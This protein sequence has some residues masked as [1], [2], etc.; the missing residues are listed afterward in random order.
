MNKKASLLLAISFM[1]FSNPLPSGAFSLGIITD[2]HAGGAKEVVKSEKN[3]LY[4]SNYCN[5][6]KGVKE[7]GVD[8]ILTLGD[9]TLNGKPSEA[10]RVIE[11]MNG[12]NILWAKGNHDKEVA[13]K[14]FNTPNYYSK[15]IDNWKII[16]LDSSK[17][18][19]ADSGGFLDE[20]LT[21]LENELNESNNEKIFIAMHHKVFNPDDFIINKFVVL[22]NPSYANV[23]FHKFFQ[24]VIIKQYCPVFFPIYEKFINMIESNGKVKYVYSGHVHKD[25]GCFQ[26]NGVNYCAVPSLSTGDYEGYFEKLFLE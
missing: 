2:I 6:L 3:I 23:V 21:W 9:N 26:I 5:N 19:P 7:S 20:Q 1:F 8:Y 11:C 4:P 13:W 10:K 18:F 16:V 14:Y 12:Y 15:K 17:L 22:S 24:P 25:N